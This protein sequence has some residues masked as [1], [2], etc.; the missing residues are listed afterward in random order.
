MTGGTTAVATQHII[1]VALLPAGRID[2]AVTAR[3]TASH[4]RPCA[5]ALVGRRTTTAV[6]T[7]ATASLEL[8]TGTTAVAGGGVSVVALLAAQ[9]VHDAISAPRTSAHAR[10]GAVALVG[11]RTG[12]AVVAD[13]PARLELASAATAI[14]VEDIAVVA[15]LPAGGIEHA[16]S[17]HRSATDTKAGS[18]ALIDR[19]ARIAVIAGASLRL[20]LARSAT[21]I[22]IRRVAVVALLSTSGVQRTISAG[23]A[24]PDAGPRSIARVGRRAGIEVVAGAAERFELADAATAVA[25]GRIAVVALLP[26]RGVQG[27]I[28]ASRATACAKA[29]AIALIYRTANVRIVTRATR[30]LEGA[31]C[32]AAVT[33]CGIAVIALLAAGAVEG[34]V[35]AERPTGYAGS[36]AVAPIRRRARVPVVARATDDLELTGAAAAVTRGRVAIVA[37]LAAVRI[38]HTVPAGR[39]ASR[40]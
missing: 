10:S 2:D 3:A 11:R 32:A 38:E 25:V 37:L 24:A 14:A 8:A 21:A 19:R 35:A 30:C 15:L 39:A 28:A 4:T 17:A 7:G 36:R 26:A 29:G 5:V 9:R 18:I 31:S 6:V 33:A 20:E 27:A 12:I 1:V 22:A 40:A 13:A 34:A 23:R 16:V